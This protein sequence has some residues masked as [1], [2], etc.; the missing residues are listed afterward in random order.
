MATEYFDDYLESKKALGW[1]AINSPITVEEKFIKITGPRA[2]FGWVK[3]SAQPADSFSY[4]SRAKWPS[5]SYDKAI[6]LGLFDVLVSQ[7]M[8]PIFGLS[9]EVEEIKWHEID[10]C[11]FGY[12][13]AARKAAL[14]IVKT[15]NINFEII[16]DKK[17]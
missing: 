15:E 8:H 3:I 10:S 13:Q 7:D 2:L 12:Y 6:F 14:N 17:S 5:D 1:R 9:I 16:K 11:Y 4:I